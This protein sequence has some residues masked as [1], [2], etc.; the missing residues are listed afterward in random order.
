MLLGLML[1]SL[2]V[3]AVLL[4]RLALALDLVVLL[5]EHLEVLLEV[6]LGLLVCSALGLRGTLLEGAHDVQGHRAGLNCRAGG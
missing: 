5:G 6:L 2:E 4:L 3:S 1:G